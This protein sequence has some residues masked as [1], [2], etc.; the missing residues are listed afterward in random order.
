MATQP[1]ENFQVPRDDI[2][3]PKWDI[4]TG[5]PNLTGKVAIVTGANSSVGIGYHVAHQLAIKGAK[6]YVG[7][8]NVQKAQA[9][10]EEMRKDTPSIAEG[11][12]VPLAMDLGDLKEVLKIAR[13]FVA[14]EERL[15]IL[16]NNAGLLPRPLDKDKNGISVSFGTNHLAPFLFTNE[17]LPLLKQ[18]SVISP[19]VRVVNLSSSTH[20]APPTGI[21][22]DSLAAFNQEL[23]GTDDTQSNYIRYGLSKL[24]NILFAKELQKL[25]DAEGI[26]AVA[27]SVNPGGVKT[28]EVVG[29]INFVGENV[30]LLEDARTPL[31]GALTPLFAATNPIVWV[32]KQKYGGAYLVPF[33][34]VAEASDDGRNTQLAK[35]LWATSE[36]VINSVL[37]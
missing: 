37:N 34:V 3:G 16:V 17:L 27:V 6:V 20:S 2:V 1:F 28:G 8:R 10:I 11:K 22:L 13:E 18:T 24:A 15:D 4:Q 19:G 32:E 33:G 21:K 26:Q 12:L 23:G 29:T 30:A 9:A 31:E 35:D 25:F 7:A 36:Q 14:K 5:I